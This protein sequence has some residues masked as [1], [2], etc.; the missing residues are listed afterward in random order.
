MSWF[1]SKSAYRIRY[2]PDIR[3]SNKLHLY[4][5]YIHSPAPETYQIWRCEALLPEIQWVALAEG[6][7]CNISGHNEARAF[8]MTDG[9]QPSLVAPNTVAR[10]YKDHVKDGVHEDNDA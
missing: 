7:L 6:S 3:A 1:M 4:D 9:G 5:F 2:P 8:I 10:L